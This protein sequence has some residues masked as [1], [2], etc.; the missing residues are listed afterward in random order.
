MPGLAAAATAAVQVTDDRGR[1]L[2]LPA[3]PQRIVSLLPSLTETVCELQACARLVGTDR[4]S[5]WPEAVRALPKLGGLEDSQI[6]RI[7]SL[8]PDLV[9]VAVAARAIDRLEALGL[10]VLAL[11]PRNAAE[12]RRVIERVALALGEPAAGAAL[13]ARIEGRVAAAASRVP[14]ALR[15]ST[16]YFEVAA[17]PYAAGEASF[18]GELLA[19]LGLVNIVPAS[20]GPFPQLNPEFVLRAQPAVVMATAA[21]VA[22]MPRRPG[23]AML[24][25]LQRGQ[26]CGFD[27]GTYDTLVRPGPRLGD[28]AEAIADCLVRLVRLG[29]MP[30]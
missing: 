24:H 7:V 16:V 14:P 25:A 28:A 5:N 17:N 27:T 21:A 22:E 15:G 23:W 4:F 12:T 29:T 11:E 13:V 18:V 30:P 10:P 19:R 20:M 8:K 1:T 26:F 2:T 3:P 9:L 6:E